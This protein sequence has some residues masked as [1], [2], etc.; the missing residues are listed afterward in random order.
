MLLSYFYTTFSVPNDSFRILYTTRTI[1]VL[2]NV[3]SSRNPTVQVGLSTTHMTKVEP[4]RR[5]KTR[6]IEGRGTVFFF[7]LLLCAYRRRPRRPLFL[8]V[9]SDGMGVTS[10]ILPIFNPF[11]ASAL[12]A[13]W[14]PGPGLRL[15]FPP[16]PRTLM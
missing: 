3:W 2:S 1:S 15:L 11:R 16:V 7:L 4:K 6:D 14:A 10:S 13:D 8:R 5:K 12:N 9:Q